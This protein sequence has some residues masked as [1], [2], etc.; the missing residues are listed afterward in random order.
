MAM[1]FGSDV[2]VALFGR[3]PHPAAVKIG[4]ASCRE[5][6][7]DLGG[8]RIIK[9]KMVRVHTAVARVTLPGTISQVSAPP[10][11]GTGSSSTPFVAVPVNVVVIEKTGWSTVSYVASTGVLS[12]STSA[13]V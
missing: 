8:R 6:G 11:V 9:K 7:V 12:R 2:T 13:H 3:S 10:S 5:S 4:R 1:R